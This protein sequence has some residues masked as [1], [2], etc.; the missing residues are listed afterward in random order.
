[1]PSSCP[2]DVKIIRSEEKV[3]RLTDF[4]T[5]AIAASH[6]VIDIAIVARSFES[7]VISAVSA[8]LSKRGRGPQA[9]NLQLAE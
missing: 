3:S 8:E 4:V 7:P 6:G 2:G 1:M 5:E 9:I